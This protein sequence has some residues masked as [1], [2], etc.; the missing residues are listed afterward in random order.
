MRIRYENTVEDLITFQLHFYECS[1]ALRR[2]ATGW[3]WGGVA[4][5][6]GAPFF[7]VPLVVDALIRSTGAKIVP[8]I[9]LYGI[10]LVVAIVAASLYF[11]RYPRLM[12]QQSTKLVR[13]IYEEDPSHTTDEW[14]ELELHENGLIART[15]VKEN[16]YAWGAIEK[17]ESTP[18]YTFIWVGALM[19]HIIPHHRI[20]EGDLSSFLAE[21]GSR[22][23]SHSNNRDGS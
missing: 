6:I 7:V 1:P 8:G 17:I 2:S 14:H 23:N 22:F 21:L 20:T 13:K 18:S 12:R 19:A 4:L 9:E 10:I 16:N 11:L 3:R 15:S 5:I